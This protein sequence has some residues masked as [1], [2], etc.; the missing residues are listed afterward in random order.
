MTF[1]TNYIASNISGAGSSVAI[2]TATNEDAAALNALIQ[3]AHAQAGHTT[4]AAVEIS[5]SDLLTLRNGDRLMTRKNDRDL[6]VANRDVWNVQRVHRS[7]ASSSIIWQS[8]HATR[9]RV[10]AVSGL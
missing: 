2:A 10:L 4:T 3:Q 8:A 6:G 5:G 1:P 9:S 7:G